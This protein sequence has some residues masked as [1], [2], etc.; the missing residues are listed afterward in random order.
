MAA[1]R[2]LLSQGYSVD[3]IGTDGNTALCSAVAAGDRRAVS[4]LRAFRAD[5]Q[6]SCMARVPAE[7]YQ[8]LIGEGQPV[9]EPVAAP[10]SS[11]PTGVARWLGTS[12]AAKPAAAATSSAAV[13]ESSIG[14]G[15]WALLGAG[16]AAVVGG[17]IALAGGG[18]SDSSDDAGVVPEDNKPCPTNQHRE[19]GVCV[20]DEGLLMFDG[21][22]Y[23]P[24]ICGINEHQKLDGCECDS[25]YT[26]QADGK[27]YQTLSCGVNEKQEN[28]ACV[29]LNDSYV[30]DQN[31]KCYPNQNCNASAGWLQVGD[32]C[33]CLAAG[34][35]A[36]EGGCY[37]EKTCGENR[38]QKGDACVC[39]SDFKEFDGVCYRSRSC[40]TN[41]EQY[42]D[43]CQCRGGYVRDAGGICY[44]NMN[45]ADK[46][47]HYEQIGNAC[48]CQSGYEEIDGACRQKQT[49]GVNEK[50]GANGCECLDSSYIRDANGACYKNQNCLASE[51]QQQVGDVCECMNG[52]IFESGRCFQDLK[53]SETDA[54]SVQSAGACVC[55]S[56]YV[57]QGSSCILSM[58]CSSA[59]HKEQQGNQC[60]CVAGYVM[61]GD[62][63]YAQKTDCGENRVQFE[64][65]CVCAPDFTE[66]DGVCYANVT[67]QENAHQQGASCE[68][69]EGFVEYDGLC[70][71]DAT[72]GMNQIQQGNDCVCV[73]GY[74][75]TDGECYLDAN[76]LADRNEEQ[77]KDQC[78]CKTGYVDY[79]GT[80]IAQLSCSEE[81]NRVQEGTACVCKPGY[82]ED[83]GDKKCY[84]DLE[85]SR[86]AHQVQNKNECVCESEA[87]TKYS[88]GICK[89][90]KDCSGDP[91]TKVSEDGESC[92]CQEGYVRDLFASCQ[93]DQHCDAAAFKVQ[94]GSACVCMSGYTSFDGNQTCVVIETCVDPN[95][96]F[97]P[98]GCECPSDYVM[99]Y[100]G[101]CQQNMNCR[102]DQVQ[103]G[104]ECRCLP[105]YV[106][107]N[108]VCH[109]DLN[110][111]EGQKQEGDSCVCE[112]SSKILL[113]GVCYV[114][115]NCDTAVSRQ[116]LNECVCLTGYRKNASGQCVSAEKS[117][118]DGQYWTGKE[119]ATLPDHAQALTDSAS[120]V[121]KAHGFTC[122]AGYMRVNN[123][124]ILIPTT[125]EATEGFISLDGTDQKT[126][127][128]KHDATTSA[129]SGGLVLTASDDKDVLAEN[130]GTINM[131]ALTEYAVEASGVK[132][133]A[134]NSGTLTNGDD[135]G[136]AL[137][138]KAVGGASVD[139]SG[140][141]S[142]KTTGE[143]GASYGLFAESTAQTAISRANNYGTLTID[144]G[145]N[146][147]VT[148]LYAATSTGLASAQN[149]GNMA[150]SMS[151][152]GLLSGISGSKADVLN[153]G[154]MTLTAQG[155]G[156]AIGASGFDGGAVD[157]TG[158]IDLTVSGSTAGGGYYA[159]L[160]GGI[161]V[162]QSG[163]S[164]ILSPVKNE[165]DITLDVT[166]SYQA[167]QE[168]KA[169]NVPTGGR[170]VAGIYANNT[171]TNSGRVTLSYAEQA[172]I[173]KGY[174]VLYG[175]RSQKG[176]SLTNSSDVVLNNLSRSAGYAVRLE[177]GSLT[178]AGVIQVN[179]GDAVRSAPDTAVGTLYG[180]YSSS[181]GTIS[182]QLTGLIDVNSAKGNGYGIYASS[183]QTI[184]NEGRVVLRAFGGTEAVGIVGRN[185]S[186]NGSLFV[187]N[188]GAATAVGIRGSG[189][190]TIAE[191]ATIEMDFL[192]PSV[193][194]DETADRE[195]WGVYASGKAVNSGK[196]SIINSSGADVHGMHA[197]SASA[198]VINLGEI[199][200]DN[201][202]KNDGT[203]YGLSS[204]GGL[205]RNEG[206]IIIKNMA[207][208]DTYGIYGSG[209]LINAGHLEIQNQAETEGRSY[210]IYALSGSSVDNSG[211]ILIKRDETSLATSYGI[212][213]EDDTVT[214][215][216]TGTITLERGTVSNSYAN[217]N[218]PDGYYIY[219]DQA[220]TAE[221]AAIVLNGATLKTSGVFESDGALDLNA[222]GGVMA[223]SA[224]GEYVAPAISGDLLIAADVVQDGFETVYTQKGALTTNDLSGLTVASESPLF[225]AQVKQNV[226][227]SADVV[228]SLKGFDTMA[229]TASISAFLT[230]N[231]QAQ[232]GGDFFMALKQASSVFE[233][234]KIVAEKLGSN[235]IPLFVPEAFA[236]L[237]G[238]NR[239][240]NQNMFDTT[241]ET[242][243][244]V[245]VDVA[246]QSRKEKGGL[247]GYDHY[248]NSIYGVF[249]RLLNDH[250][251]A[252]LAV[253]VT[254]TNSDYDTDADRDNILAQI[255]LPLT[256]QTNRSRLGFK[257]ISAP[258]VGYAYE[259]WSRPSGSDEYEGRMQN[260]IYG[261]TNEM[262][263]ALTVGDDWFVVE[264]A[265]E[266]NVLG[267]VSKKM[268]EHNGPNPLTLKSE[269][270]LSFES[271]VGAYVYKTFNMSDKTSLKASLGAVWYHE[272]LKPYQ[273]ISSQVK[274]FDGV[275]KMPH[276]E[277][278]HDRG[279]VSGRV[280][281]S[282]GRF[283]I[284]GEAT[285][286]IEN[287]SRFNAR[288]GAKI[289]F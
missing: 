140:I 178:N 167:G 221:P 236:A 119:C 7:Q 195:A 175:I 17:G 274:G 165:G 242:R 78:R 252:G 109:F 265:L 223:L 76:C 79:E 54:N 6:H 181:S 92:L 9:A 36:Q 55:K 150:L 232:H 29:C 24:K 53:C 193:S 99:D 41:E 106:E 211:T 152:S 154:T 11:E 33:Q 51:G 26:R 100:N 141:I 122:A 187:Q 209:S 88:D 219:V 237:R 49:C 180:V 268:H 108:G 250:V 63:C 96:V 276:L 263:Y 270:A 20:C 22:C 160:L 256:Y 287:V 243:S 61:F 230:Q 65:R 255:A 77:Y 214:I 137:G 16:A 60:V 275:Y 229:D 173:D 58:N 80:C 228:L 103:F 170:W 144:A 156:S 197:A 38:V 267:M 52:Y 102:A 168:M 18:G 35:V 191:G 262:R 204:N 135:A 249:D 105:G 174:Y 40:G 206:T 192:T 143:Q 260:L 272:F 118:S 289:A 124:C 1:L 153:S 269:N 233:G 120:A 194:E 261:V 89:E 142:L 216:N 74:H 283:G 172:G 42:K 90:T 3:T 158:K 64:D 104:E 166:L 264:P 95:A 21:V 66:F 273:N 202:L 129:Q 126:N 68:C 240:M 271:G 70:Y 169:N 201:S 34:F 186:H 244:L 112:D 75:M 148:G 280:D 234:K 145:G 59:D 87:Y 39:A 213:A 115:L 279:L 225:D 31:G 121:D 277:T 30:R 132:A 205:A 241:D 235:L 97:G 128:F 19:N 220:D 57:L 133:V 86:Y 227:G 231:Y 28:G 210:G 278:E 113:N 198:S 146:Q 208:E 288:V 123:A 125:P 32:S 131:N 8:A 218:A 47:E 182:N 184:S 10:A 136:V 163:V 94:E 127:Y 159:G 190:I 81:D 69:D 285:Q 48:V 98:N 239:A 248:A 176:I 139:N 62:V 83:S 45:C 72:C 281:V 217:N 71:S 13:S 185:V 266:L 224:G 15:T 222:F 177:G 259:K 183:A 73:T 151:G 107:V 116:V 117:C 245:G 207:M 23:E 43:A 25:G 199:F 44:P 85:C 114:N 179:P 200:I 67:C 111:G 247:T 46:G 161:S 138:M 82:V 253:T 157:N 251:R 12:E 14:V 286:H 254:H 84:E 226:D 4:L 2:S 110:C 284:Y 5:T 188:I 257:Y 56:G 189:D 130:T 101:R 246:Y 203:A 196:I 91:N 37:L 50:L 93:P 238:V 215:S 282:Y 171:V 258:R 149:A 147:S 155:S 162:V 164:S 134:V 27:C 212:W